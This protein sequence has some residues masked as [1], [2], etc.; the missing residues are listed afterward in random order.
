METSEN[1]NKNIID[2]LGI[3][4]G[5]PFSEIKRLTKYLEDYFEADNSPVSID[6]IIKSNRLDHSLRAALDRIY[7]AANDG[8]T[9]IVLFSLVNNS[10]FNRYTST[11]NPDKVRYVLMDVIHHKLYR[12]IES[13]EFSAESMI[14]FFENSD[15]P[16]AINTLIMESNNQYTIK[17]TL[18]EI[19]E[20]C[21]K[22]TSELD[23]F[24]N[25]I[26]EPLFL[27][28]CEN[29][30]NSLVADFLTNLSH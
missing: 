21:V 22:V 8:I 25:I 20:N 2:L 13:I 12:F 26:R 1:A 15:S 23:T 19:C 5:G 24:Y 10:K 7:I 9:A 30:F 6:I 16:L 27:I 3:S 17:N 18:G 28:K 11:T 4:V 29:S 14:A